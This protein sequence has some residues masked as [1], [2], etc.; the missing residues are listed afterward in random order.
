MQPFLIK[1]KPLSPN[2]WLLLVVAMMAL[3][4]AHAQQVRVTQLSKK[5]DKPDAVQLWLT[6]PDK[7]VLF[8]TQP[9]RLGFGAAPNGH[10]SIA[11]DD[12]EAY[13][14]VDGF[15][16]CLTGGSALLLHRMAATERAKLLREL[17]A[18]D[19]SNIGVSYLRLSIGASDLDDRVFSYD[20][21][22]PGK[23][24]PTLAQFS[25]APDREHLIPV[26]QEIL[27]IN[28]GIKLLGSPWSPPPG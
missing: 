9:S 26:L 5:K 27:A 12:K 4:A 22:R 2:R 15:G 1:W 3:A 17:F 13:Q 14:T 18:T 11:I 20:D 25:L 21:Q 8:Q 6:T 24:D 19:G 10:P 16:Y 28:P 23:T 7:S